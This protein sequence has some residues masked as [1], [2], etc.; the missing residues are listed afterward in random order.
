MCLASPGNQQPWYWL[1][2]INGTSS[3]MRKDLTLLW[4]LCEK[5]NEM[6]TYFLFPNGWSPNGKIMYSQLVPGS[7]QGCPLTSMGNSIVDKTTIDICD[8]TIIKS[9]CRDKTTLWS[10][11]IY[12]CSC[13]TGKLEMLYWYPIMTSAVTA[14]AKFVSNIYTI[15]NPSPVIIVSNCL[16]SSWTNPNINLSKSDSHHLWVCVCVW[17]GG[18]FQN[19]GNL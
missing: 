4:H 3:S 5:L 9:H 6:Q 2:M 13:C 8:K 17:G 7:I 10:S 16:G 12:S 18:G 1:C 11:Y 14:M 15:S 19:V